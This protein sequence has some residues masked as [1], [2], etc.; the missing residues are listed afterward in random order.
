MCRKGLATL[1]HHRR[2][3]D[4]EKGARNAKPWAPAQPHAPSASVVL[5]ASRDVPSWSPQGDQCPDCL[6][7]TPLPSRAPLLSSLRSL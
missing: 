7:S 2:A 6:A 3:D 5:G 4:M 1:P